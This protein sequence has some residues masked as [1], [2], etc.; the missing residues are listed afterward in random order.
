MPEVTCAYRH[1]NIVFEPR[2]HNQVY[3]TSEHCREETNIRLKESYHS[4]KARRAGQKRV[5]AKPGCGTL[6]SRYNDM[7]ICSGCIAEEQAQKRLRDFKVFT[8]EA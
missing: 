5:C 2:R 8:G 4:N 3:C 6:L 1:C 7:T